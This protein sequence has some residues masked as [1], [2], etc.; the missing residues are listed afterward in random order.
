[1]KNL[2]VAVSGGRSSAMMAYHIHTSD[3]YKDFEKIYVFANTGMERPETIQFLK[4]INDVWGIPLTLIEGKYSKTMGIG[5]E[6]QIVDFENLNMN[7]LPFE[8]AIMHKNKGIF[9]GLPNQE[10]PYCSSAMKTIPCEKFANEI[11]GKNNYIK[12]IGYRREDMPKRISWPEVRQDEKRIF[13]LITDFSEPIGLT[14]LNAWWNTQSFQLGVN[15]KFSNCELCWKKSDKNIVE[16]IRQ[17]T[18]FV[19]WWLRMEE[20]YGNTAFRNRK[21]IADFVSI[22]NQPTTMEIDFSENDGCVC[23]F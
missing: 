14:E 5:I 21:S 18:R 2:L 23:T 15:S 20:Q 9:D 17:G 16:S 8:E 3:E 10:S 4:N 7:A 19:D 6:Y 1:M 11:F 12:A 22:A 13:P